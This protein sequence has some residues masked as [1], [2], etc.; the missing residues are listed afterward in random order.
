MQL[1][2][3]SVKINQMT[4]TFLVASVSQVFINFRYTFS[5]RI[6]TGLLFSCVGD[7]LLIWPQYFIYGMGA[8]A[9]AQIMYTAAFGFKPLNAPLG[10]A[11][12]VLGTVGKLAQLQI[13]YS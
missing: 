12:Y 10:I 5:R 1:L 11:L 3:A 2:V 13:R 9:V 7:A 6:L 4:L 8:F